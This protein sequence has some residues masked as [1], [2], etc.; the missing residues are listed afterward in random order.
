MVRNLIYADNITVIVGTKLIEIMERV[1]K[2]SKETRLYR[3]ILNTKIK[4]TGDIEDVTVGGKMVDV[5]TIF[6]FLG[7]LI[8]RDG[9]CDKEIRRGIA[10]D[11]DSSFSSRSHLVVWVAATDTVDLLQQVMSWTSSF[12]VP[13]AL[14]SRLTQSIHICFGLRRFLLPGATISRV[15][16]PTS[17]LSRLLR[18]LPNHAP[19][20]RFHAPLCDAL[21]L[22]SPIYVFVSLK[23]LSACGRTPNCTSSFLSLPVSSRGI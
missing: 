16:L 18:A 7:A 2:T 21:Y 12:V 8:I 4:T 14:M 5:V 17:Y 13:M 3:N 23:G 19:Q 15:C 6:I 11:K 22:Q 9:L 20:S 1:T 10:M